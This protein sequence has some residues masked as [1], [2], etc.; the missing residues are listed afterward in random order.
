MLQW[1]KAEIRQQ[2]GMVQGQGKGFREG[3][4]NSE[5]SKWQKGKSGEKNMRLWERNERKYY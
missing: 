5:L 4:N 3:K 1:W 2:N